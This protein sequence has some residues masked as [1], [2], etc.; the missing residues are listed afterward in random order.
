M[1]RFAAPFRGSLLACAILLAAQLARGAAPP[2]L[3]ADP[4]PGS[5]APSAIPGAIRSRSI[6][7]DFALLDSLASGAADGLALAPF[8]DA[9]FEGIVQRRFI[10]GPQSYTLAGSIPRRPLASFTITREAGAVVGVVRDYGK[11]FYIIEPVAPGLQRAVEIDPSAQPPCGTKDAPPK[12]AAILPSQGKGAAAPP[13]KSC[14]PAYPDGEDGT[15]IDIMMVYTPAVVTAM[16]S[17]SAVDALLNMAIDNA[18]IAFPASQ[19]PLQFRLVHSEQVSY[20]DTGNLNTDLDRVTNNGDGFLDNV[21]GLRDTYRADLVGLIVTDG[22]PYCGLGWILSSFFFTT[23]YYGYSASAYACLYGD[24]YAHEAGH[25]MGCNHDRPNAGGGGLF[26]YSYGKSFVGQSSNTWGT[27]MSYVGTRVLHYSNP[28]VN[29]DGVPTGVN[30]SLPT[31]ANNAK[32][33]DLSRAFIANYRQSLIDEQF[34]VSPDDDFIASGDVGG[35][36]APACSQYTLTNNGATTLTWSLLGAPPAWLDAS[37]TTGTIAPLA[38]QFVDVCIDA[39]ATSLTAGIYQTTLSFDVGA[40]GI[41]RRR[42]ATLRVA[43]VASCPFADSFDTAAE[44]REAWGIGGTNEWCI[45]TV[46]SGGNPDGPQSIVLHEDGLDGFSARTEL[47]LTIDLAGKQRVRLDFQVK[48]NTFETIDGNPPA[49][50]ITPQNYDGIAISEDGATWHVIDRYNGISTFWSNKSI[51]LDPE[52]AAA[53]ISYNSAFKI[54]F[55]Q[56]G[57]SR[58]PNYGILLDDLQVFEA[59]NAARSWLDYE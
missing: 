28:L 46:S 32:T 45:N 42:V 15:V 12:P 21:Q 7:V 8:D 9:A 37:P 20:T 56:Y 31:S 59:P 43:G 17:V 36:F 39:S 47:T 24:T 19:V 55:T 6:A 26:A 2:L 11:A 41:S 50:Y 49:S 4:A 57:F 22:G 27:I 1:P 54:R 18:N 14:L 23:G 13:L 5:L 34:S 52:I 51:D 33:I 10:R 38:S 16:G 44:P 40:T 35:P 3:S 30:E 29:Y 48:R 58:H 25:N 53:G